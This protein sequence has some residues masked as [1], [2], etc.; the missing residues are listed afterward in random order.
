MNEI[1]FIRF[2]HS[3]TAPK[4]ATI[5]CAR[6]DLFSADKVRIKPKSVYA[7]TTDIGI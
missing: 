5:D 2:S 1:E 4:R 6:Y 7:V 3:A